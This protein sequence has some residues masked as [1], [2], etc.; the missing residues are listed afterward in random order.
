MVYEWY[1]MTMMAL[2]QLDVYIAT[3]LQATICI[4]GRA[5]LALAVNHAFKAPPR[6]ASPAACQPLAL[7]T[8]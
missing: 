3:T 6:L 7:R 2:V 5:F 4:A 8:H 1:S